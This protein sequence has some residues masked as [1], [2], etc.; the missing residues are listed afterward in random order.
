MAAKKARTSVG[1]TP[2]PQIF[3]GRELFGWRLSGG[4][5]I[6]RPAVMKHGGAVTE[7]H[8]RRPRPHFAHAPLVLVQEEDTL[9]ALHAFMGGVSYRAVSREW[10]RA[11]ARRGLWQRACTE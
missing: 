7:L 1:Y 8:E 3:A 11:R 2:P 10:V 5:Q 9:V 6:L 4:Q